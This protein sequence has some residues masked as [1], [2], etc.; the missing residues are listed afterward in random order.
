MSEHDEPSAL[1]DF[2]G[3]S[4]L[5]AIDI[6]EDL[7]LSRKLRDDLAAVAEKHSDA[8]PLA[9]IAQIPEMQGAFVATVMGLEMQINAL[10]KLLSEDDN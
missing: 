4:R 5:R 7:A 2:P 10:R 3:L 9:L 6:P 1:D 8:T